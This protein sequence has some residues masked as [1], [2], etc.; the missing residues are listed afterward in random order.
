MRSE[1]LGVVLQDMNFHRDATTG[2]EGEAL[3]RA[4]KRLDRE[5][6]VLLMTA[7][8]SLETAVRLVQG[9]ASD[10]IAK[11]WNDDKLVATVKNLLRLRELSREWSERLRQGAH[12]ADRAGQFPA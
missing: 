3:L 10:Y 9:G 8:Q 1:D 11:R 12:R 5:L 2:E 4:I 6:P 7:F